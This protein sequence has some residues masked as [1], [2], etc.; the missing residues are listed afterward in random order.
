MDL[1]NLREKAY[2]I[3]LSSDCFAH[4]FGYAEEGNLGLTLAAVEQVICDLAYEGD[5]SQIEA[6]SL[7]R[8]ALADVE[9]AMKD[10]LKGIELV[11]KQAGDSGPDLDSDAIR[12]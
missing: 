6:A 10:A 1:K 9:A 11:R 3:A 12:L 7:R 2:E 5:L 4:A 8:A